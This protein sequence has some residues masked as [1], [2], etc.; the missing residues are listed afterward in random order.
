MLESEGQGL[1]AQS[2]TCQL[3][4]IGKFTVFGGWSLHTHQAVGESSEGVLF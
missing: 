3:R 4:E 2:V 1:G